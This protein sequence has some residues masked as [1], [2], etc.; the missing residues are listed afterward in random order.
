M[1]GRQHCSGLFRGDLKEARAQWLEN[2]RRAAAYIS[3]Q[4]ERTQQAH[5]ERDQ[6]Q[7]LKR[8]ELQ[9]QRDL[10]ANEALS[11]EAPKSQPCRR[12][13]AQKRPFSALYPFTTE[14]LSVSRRPRSHA[15]CR[16]LLQKNEAL[17]QESFVET[18]LREGTANPVDLDP[19]LTRDAVRDGLVIVQSEGTYLTSPLAA[20]ASA[21]WHVSRPWQEM[22]SKIFCEVQG[23]GDRLTLRDDG[24]LGLR[25]L[26]CGS[27]NAVFE[28]VKRAP[29]PEW[30]PRDCV[31][32]VTRPDKDVDKE[33]R[34]QTISMVAKEAHNALFAAQNGF[35][36][37]IYAIAGFQGV[38]SARTLRYG[39]VYALQ[40]ADC[41]LNSVLDRAP[42]MEAGA[43]IAVEVTDLVFSASRCGIAFYDIKPGNIL[44]LK[45]SKGRLCFKLC[46]FDSS[47]FQIVPRVDWRTLMLIN[48]A[49][50]SAHV[51]NGA[52]GQASLGWA[53]AV[54]DVLKDMLSMRGKLDNE[55]LFKVRS[56]KTKCDGSDSVTP[57]TMGHLL[58]IMATSYFYGE[59]VSK[60]ACSK[61]WPHWN[62][63]PH[64]KQLDAHWEVA[65]RRNSWPPE[66]DEGSESESYTPLIQQLVHFSIERAGGI[67]AHVC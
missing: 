23:R 6:Q 36:V 3:L 27:F 55:W 65:K 43:R 42:D 53:T 5:K 16:P 51:R 4:Q 20:V 22:A 15:V 58:A 59:R 1:D 33:H 46:D 44:Q 11:P 40:K 24:G 62:I 57:F 17:A 66:W 10:I 64:Q 13:S 35:G 30:V 50:L 37:P 7:E 39:T 54:S 32:R 28:F 2:K 31:I 26:G 49:L 63:H 25:L 14:T 52:F 47:F 18:A 8:M 56:V 29:F 12:P 34:Y 41:D 67:C 48:L 19:F 61:R 60:D 45:D 38:R 9:R 21:G